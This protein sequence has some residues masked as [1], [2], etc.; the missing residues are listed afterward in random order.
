MNVVTRYVTNV[1]IYVCYIAAFA[2]T[3]YFVDLIDLLRLQARVC[4]WLRCAHGYVTFDFAL[5]LRA[6][7]GY[8]HAVAVGHVCRWTAL[9][10]RLPFTVAALHRV[11]VCTVCGGRLFAV[12]RITRLLVTF[13]VT[14]CRVGCCV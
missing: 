3:R 13:H 11:V 14:L 10:L 12:T 8:A 6:R 7:F 4:D 2:V 5:I 9:T 1:T